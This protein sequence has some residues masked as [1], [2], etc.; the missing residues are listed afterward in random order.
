MIFP[1]VVIQNSKSITAVFPFQWRIAI[2]QMPSFGARLVI[3]S[4]LQIPSYLINCVFLK[5]KK[6]NTFDVDTGSGNVCERV[7]ERTAFWGI[8]FPVAITWL[9]VGAFVGN[10]LN[11][12]KAL[13]ERFD[14]SILHHFKCLST[15]QAASEFVFVFNYSWKLSSRSLNA[16]SMCWW[17]NFS[18]RLT[19]LISHVKSAI[20]GTR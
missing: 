12:Y 3:A 2:I 15:Q 10:S 7:R 9:A 14:Y 8:P 4:S 1:C 18:V 19:S 6:E 17:E 13:N 11:L 5:K 16:P 20:V